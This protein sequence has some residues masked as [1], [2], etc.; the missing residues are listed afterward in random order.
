[1]ILVAFW[2]DFLNVYRFVLLYRLWM[3]TLW[4]VAF[5]HYRI[6][7]ADSPMARQS[8]DWRGRVWVGRNKITFILVPCVINW[9]KFHLFI[10]YCTS[11]L[12]SF[13][14]ILFILYHLTGS[15]PYL[16]DTG[17]SI[18]ILYLVFVIY[19]ISILFL[20]VYGGELGLWNGWY[21]V[22]TVYRGVSSYHFVVVEFQFWRHLIINRF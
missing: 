1:M 18:L 12:H 15:S 4:V 2:L 20:I 3:E 19:L 6:F 16:H 11:H 17:I 7:L 8:Q 22:A 10:A 5:T 13:W 9:V 14:G 21:H